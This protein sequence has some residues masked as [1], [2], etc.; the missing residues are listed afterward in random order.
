MPE[1]DETIITRFVVEADEAV[2]KAQEFRFV[3]NEIKEQLKVLPKEAKENLAV[4]SKAM[5]DAFRTDRLKQ[6]R[7]E[8]QS[9]LDVQGETQKAQ[10]DI[11]TYSKAMTI[12]L[13]E[14][15]Q[16]ETILDKETSQQAQIQSNARK[17]EEQIAKQAAKSIADAE[18]TKQQAA[19]DAAQNIIRNN[20]QQAAAIKNLEDQTKQSTQGFRLFGHEIKNIGDV[21]RV[22]LIGIFGVSVI[23]IIRNVIRGF[24]EAAQAGYEF[25]KSIFQLE[26]GPRALQR[27]GVDITIQQIYEQIGLL[28]ERFKIF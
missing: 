18:K 26:V 14:V 4:V 25:A 28:Q 15:R 2:K 8:L 7:E 1:S 13:R 21:A 11:Q 10:A 17:E 27:A 5:I 23:Q 20:Q 12:A 16:E 3:I 19:R 9:S 22:V 6:M 24:G